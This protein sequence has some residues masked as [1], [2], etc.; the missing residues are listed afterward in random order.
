MKTETKAARTRRLLRLAVL[1]ASLLMLAGPFEVQAAKK[2]ATE[3]HGKYAYFAVDNTIYRMNSNTGTVRKICAVEGVAMIG[4]IS[5]YNGYLYF[6]A[7][8]Y[9]GSDGSEYRIYR[10]RKNGKNLQELGY[11]IHPRIYNGKLYYAAAAIENVDDDEGKAPQ[12]MV[13][14]LARCKTNGTKRKILVDF[15]DERNWVYD[16]E[17]IGGRI[18]YVAENSLYSVKTSG[19]GQIRH[20]DALDMKSDGTSI[21]LQTE[22]EIIRFRISSGITPI[23]KTRWS[24]GG[25]PLT[26]LVYVKSGYLYY[27]EVDEDGGTAFWRVRISTKKKKKLKSYNIVE[28]AAASGSYVAV[29]RSMGDGS[30]VL[31]KMKTN[32]KK[33]KKIASYFRS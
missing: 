10:I 24:E 9:H 3:A 5:Y 32:G 33:Y 18:Y 20:F 13:Y 25:E 30:H 4:K 22:D 29:Y 31:A 12:T 19:K 8:V 16:L 14:G 17:I 28:M 26:C 27:K 11:G 15:P 7:N 2:M 6:D 21:Y 1:F 23:I